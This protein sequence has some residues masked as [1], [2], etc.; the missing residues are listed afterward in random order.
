LNGDGAAAP[1]Q[2]RHIPRWLGAQPGVLGDDIE[3]PA[4]GTKRSAE[5]GRDDAML[6]GSALGSVSG[7]CARR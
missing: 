4:Y 6:L 5:T 3:I 2:H 1:C 7:V